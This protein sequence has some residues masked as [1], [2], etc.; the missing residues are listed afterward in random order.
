MHSTQTTFFST[1]PTLKK[2]KLFDVSEIDKDFLRKN[3]AGTKFF[4]RTSAIEIKTLD[5]CLVANYEYMAVSVC[6]LIKVESGKLGWKCNCDS[7]VV[8]QVYFCLL[9]RTV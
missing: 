9:Y 4:L 5:Y 8:E 3:T 7:V 2:K 1:T 6:Q